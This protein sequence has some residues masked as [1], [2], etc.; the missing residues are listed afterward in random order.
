[1]QKKAWFSFESFSRLLVSLLL[2]CG[3][4]LPLVCA[5]GAK[6]ALGS[7]L[8]SG[9]ACLLVLWL[10]N[11]LLA[12][13]WIMAAIVCGAGLL[14][15][16]LP[17]QGLIG[18]SIEAIKAITLFIN[19]AEATTAVFAPSVALF[20]G[21]GLALLSYLF[22]HPAAGFL[23]AT[24]CVVLMFYAAWSFSES[25][26]LWLS[27]PGLIA[28]LLLVSRTS[29][30]RGNV[31][32]VL[33][34]ASVVVVLGMLLL[35]KG[36]TVI[37]PLYNAAMDLKQAIEDYLFFTDVREVFS[38]GDYGWYPMGGGQLGG[39]VEVTENPVLM[40]KSEEKLLLRGIT[41]DEY[42]GRSW[43]DNNGGKRYLYVN[44][45]WSRLRRQVFLED[46]PPLAARGASALLDEKAVSVQ[47]QNT[48]ASTLLVPAYL[49]SL[50]MSGD[51]V[52]YF[53]DSSELFITRNLQ[54]DDFYTAF[55][56]V[57]EGGSPELGA[58]IAAVSGNTADSDYDAI[59]SQYTVLPPH[60]ESKV[61][62][63]AEKMTAGFDTPYDQACAIVRN[64]Q[65]YYK[66]TLTPQT[67]PEN[68][69]FVT[70]FL[71][72]SK[73]G[74]STYFA[75]AMAVLCRMNGIPARYVEGFVCH[76]SVD[77]M[78]YVTEKD[79]HAW[80]EVYFRGFGWV[81]FDP[82]PTNNDQDEDEQET[83][84]P[85]TPP[86]EE[87]E[88]TPPPPED[89]PEDLPDEEPDEQEEPEHS[90]PKLWWLLL[91][92]AALAAVSVRVALTTP[93]RVAKK[94]TDDKEKVTVYAAACAKLLALRGITP[95]KS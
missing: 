16:V 80:V 84:P 14:Q 5:F 59:Y 28:L 51:M 19:G 9:A 60:L 4:Y 20:L 1:M 70:Y 55:A 46:L 42:T 27:V 2:F 10:I 85:P 44:P 79:A 95:K 13:H 72:V 11:T 32:E 56:P 50:N 33:P 3:L 64:L 92:A 12:R 7:G 34:V 47:V 36:Q 40:V 83:P 39:P 65:K 90:K 81:P 30:K 89:S 91:A 17:N 6:S 49:R 37:T 69:D 25:D 18:I 38:I 48:G 54:R 31:L 73:E 88:P 23:P 94:Q 21:V 15:L 86:P 35:P 77:G 58:L 66:V 29:H 71:Y 43:R 22:T 61:F 41:K 52:T 78:C 74:Y 87:Q 76:P 45:R 67:P 93:D 63:D 26:Y 53:N 82:T 68:Q 75:S 8:F 57:L 24:V 62:E